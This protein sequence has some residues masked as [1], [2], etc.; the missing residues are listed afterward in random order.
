MFRICKNKDCVKP[1]FLPHAK[2]PN[3][4]YCSNPDCQKARRRDWQRR[5]RA[6]I[7]DD[8]KDNQERAQETWVK[9]NPNYWKNYREKNPEYAER[10][11][12]LQKIRN[13]RYR[14]RLKFEN[15]KLDKIA[16]MDAYGQQKQILTGYYTLYPILIDPI[17]KMDGVLVKIDV[18]IGS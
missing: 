5:K 17:A 15:G 2:V 9:N 4:Q 18:I 3:Q 1:Y 8:Y 10:N 14:H 11:R 12:S 13:L 6:S 16:K 7:D